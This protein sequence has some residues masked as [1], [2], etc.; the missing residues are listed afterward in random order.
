[1]TQV[2][3][4][5]SWL[6]GAQRI[7]GM[8]VEQI[9][10]L[11][12][13]TALAGWFLMA[14]HSPDGGFWPTETPLRW[15][16]STS[17]AAGLSGQWANGASAWIGDRDGLFW[18]YLV[19]AALLTGHANLKD[20]PT[21]FLG[22]ATISYGAALELRNSPMTLILYLVA[23]ASICL[24][25]VLFDWGGRT[26]WSGYMSYPGKSFMT[27]ALSVAVVGFSWFS[28]PF[29]TLMASVEGYRIEQPREPE[30]PTG[31]SVVPLRS[32]PL[33][34]DRWSRLNGS[35]SGQGFS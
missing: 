19:A 30:V 6:E 34:P 23:S 4:A 17:E 31:A 26:D 2:D 32:T 16:A 25:A 15:F 7:V 21:A 28:V 14:P 22:L 13:P 3:D 5:K 29:M 11:I 1:M 10:G 12:A 35:T 33:P 18:W 8:S 24:L 9:F 27:W 20:R